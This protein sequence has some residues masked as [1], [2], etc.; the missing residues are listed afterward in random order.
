MQG[1]ELSLELH[2]KFKWFISFLWYLKEGGLSTCFANCDY[3]AGCLS[4]G[5]VE[6]LTYIFQVS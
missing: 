2:L 3:Q 5:E 1:H 6:G 4:L